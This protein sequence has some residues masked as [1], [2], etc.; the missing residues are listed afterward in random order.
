MAANTIDETASAIKSSINENPVFEYNEMIGLFLLL[1]I[2]IPQAV[3]RDFSVV[4]GLVYLYFFLRNNFKRNT[5]AVKSDFVV[6]RRK[7]EA[8]GIDKYSGRKASIQHNILTVIGI[9]ILIIIHKYGVATAIEFNHY[10]RILPYSAC[11]GHL[12][13]RGH[14]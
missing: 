1:Y 13:I 9:P 2:D 4:A 7:F 3:Y 12:E 11:L 10:R 5:P 6:D 8:G 14:I